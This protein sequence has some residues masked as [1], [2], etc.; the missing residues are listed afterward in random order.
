MEVQRHGTMYLLSSA[1]ITAIGF[2]ATIF[3][4]HW[5]GAEVLGAYFVFLSFFNILSLFT[6]MGIGSAATQRI[7]EGRD[8]CQIFT[9][10]LTLRLTLYLVVCIAA[11]IFQDRF[12]DLNASGLFWWLLISLGV[13]TLSSSIGIAIA[14]SNRLGLLASVSLLNNVTRIIIQVITVFLGFQVFGLVG[15]LIAGLI[16]E[17]ALQARYIDYHIRKFN[18]SHV[19]RIFSFSSWAFLTT[20]ATVL[21][22]NANLLIIAYFLPVSEVGIFGICWTF[23]VFALFVSTALCNTLY[24]KVSRW[25]A[26]G[27]RDT[28]S[29]SLSRATT[30]AL[31]LALPMLAGGIIL[32]KPLLYYLYGASFAAGAT[33]LVI[34]IAARIFQS[35]Y[36]LYSIYLMATDHVRMAFYGLGAGIT[37][38]I[39]LSLLLVPVMGLTGAAIASFVNVLLTITIGRHF[40]KRIVPIVIER[41]PV[42]HIVISTVIM[43]IALLLVNLVPV[44]ESAVTTFGMV[45]LGAGIY[46]LILLNLD[47][48]IRDDVFRTL[49]IQWI[50]K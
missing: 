12:A 2:I 32:G 1:G 4:A 37:V 13:L 15:G 22:D 21:F 18:F 39:I 29:A 16:V 6:D 10:N 9:A 7:C 43:T 34:I 30:Y 14:A 38:N 40:L 50:P 23:S 31:I 47:K 8:T 28:I 41:S 11:I 49:K 26:A 17:L 33:A 45:I 46:F 20:I 25:H 44:P 27:E 42:V 24:V 19:K 3:Y 36:Q 35:V 5:V 48:P